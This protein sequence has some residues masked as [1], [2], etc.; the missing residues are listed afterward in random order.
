VNH[1]L[2]SHETESRHPGSRS[3]RLRVKQLKDS[4]EPKADT[5]AN[6]VLAAKVPKRLW[7]FSD[8]SL[9]DPMRHGRTKSSTK[10]RGENR[11]VPDVVY[12]VLEQPGTPLERGSRGYFQ[13]L[14]GH[15][16]GHVRVHTGEHA[17][18]AARSIHAAAYTVGNDIVFASN[19]YSPRTLKGHLLLQ[20]ELRHVEQQ[21]SARR[22]ERA[23]LDASQS[24]HESQARSIVD[25][26]VSPLAEQRIQ[27]AEDTEEFTIGDGVVDAVGSQ[28]VGSSWPF[29]KAVFEGFVGG[30]RKDIQAGRLTEARDHLMKIFL[31]WN[32]VKYY[33][34]YLLGLVLGLISPVTDL[35]KGIIGLVKLAWSALAWLAKWSPIGIAVSPE[36]QQKILRLQERFAELGT[37]LGN[38]FAEF[39][40]NPRETVKKFTGFLDNV[41]ALALG[42]ARQIGAKAAHSIFDFLNKEFFDMGQSIG[43]VV[44][45]LIANVL[46]IV[47]SD[48]I[49]NIIKESASA[50]AKFAEAVAGKAVEVFEWVKGFAAKVIGVLRKAVE[51]ALKA[52]EGLLNKAMEAF[53]ALDALFETE[54]LGGEKV[55]AGVGKVSEGALPN[56]ME[57]RM[58]KT[59]REVPTTVEQLRTPK[60]HPS[61]IGKELP[62]E[63]PTEAPKTP[64]KTTALAKDAAALQYRDN[65][66]KRFPKLG[67]ADLRPI[68]RNLGEPGLWEESMYTGSGERTWEAKLRDGKVVRLDDIDQAGAVVDTKMRGI[69]VGREIPPEHT[70]DIVSQMG[71]K[72]ASG[73]SYPAFPESEQEKLLKQLRFSKEN[74]LTGVRWETNSRELI[75]DVN[76]YRLNI[77][78]SEEQK[79]FKIVFVQR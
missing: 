11:Q 24:R 60:V 54:A 7:S 70:P 16:F 29:L 62:K 47:F 61:N 39:A 77:L 41:M 67:E 48:A 44:G 32:M 72:T 59:T 43:E 22:V 2:L 25:L 1:A 4:S 63:L 71:G 76:R 45:A 64:P 73:R 15:D 78:S 20:H 13:N 50:A 69:G 42:E 6:D 57:A 40:K 21:R 14:F 51:G 49:G 52:F 46:L 58:V 17:G 8:L 35:V 75:A 56:I 74:G 38:S 68:A 34:G 27:R 10:A 12:D 5:A 28:V 66:V 65:L 30:L 37:E 53:K 36:R 26:S 9:S 79:L 33:G 19:R 3:T 55:A 18:K 31:P 23:P